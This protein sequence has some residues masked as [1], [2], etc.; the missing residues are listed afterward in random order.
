MTDADV[1][2]TQH[3]ES[4][5]H[6]QGYPENAP[7]DRELCGN[8]GSICVIALLQPQGQCEGQ[9]EQSEKAWSGFQH[10]QNWKI[11]PYT[12]RIGVTQNEGRPAPGNKNQ[13]HA[14]QV[15]PGWH[16]KPA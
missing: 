12:V 8:D 14:S 13:C 10:E 7:M 1:E 2:A 15:Q 6:D 11:E 4:G 3:T 16:E 9:D 5:K